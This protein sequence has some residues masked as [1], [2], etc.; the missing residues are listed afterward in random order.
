M[1]NLVDEIAEPTPTWDA[2]IE[3]SL[4]HLRLLDD[5]FRRLPSEKTDD[6]VAY[7]FDPDWAP[8]RI[9]TGKDRR[10]INAQVQHLAKRR[11]SSWDWDLTSMTSNATQAMRALL[12]HLGPQARPTVAARAEYFAFEDHAWLQAVFHDAPEVGETGP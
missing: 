2:L 3:A 9:L 12:E 4:V 6:V 1:G 5:F 10:A 8:V 7:D 11:V